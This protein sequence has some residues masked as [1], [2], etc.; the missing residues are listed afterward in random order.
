MNKK[1][2]LKLAGKEIKEST[3]ENKKQKLNEDEADLTY[4]ENRLVSAFDMFFNQ[5][6][7]ITGDDEYG[8]PSHYQSKVL[9]RLSA[10]SDEELEYLKNL[11]M[12]KIRFAGKLIN[13]SFTLGN[14]SEDDSE[15]EIE[16]EV[17]KE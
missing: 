7:G 12:R 3:N 17:E 8:Y 4:F 1:E 11:G 5:L 14:E 13:D 16:I 2:I 6:K 15:D 9:E 10:L